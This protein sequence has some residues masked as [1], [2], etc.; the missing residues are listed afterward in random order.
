LQ[1]RADSFRIRKEVL[2][3]RYVAEQSHIAVRDVIAASDLVTEG[4]R[5]APEGN[6]SAPDEIRA[7]VTGNGLA[8]IEAEIQRELGSVTSPHGLM[9]LRSAGTDISVLFAVE[10]AGTALLIAVLE[11]RDAAQ[12][13][14]RAVG[15]SADILRRVRSGADPEASACAFDDEQALI[16]ALFPGSSFTSEVGAAAQRSDP[17]MALADERNEQ[18]LSLEQVAARMGVTPQ[19]VA[20]IEQ[21]ELGSVEVGELTAYVR[22]LGGGLRVVAEFGDGPVVLSDPATPC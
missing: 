9:E 19:W 11:G 1:E 14:Y 4:I 2:K 3:A 12:Q 8:Q 13:R 15:V 20:V 5:S 18:G 10:P 22:A 16:D 7:G 17:L 21:A 6:G